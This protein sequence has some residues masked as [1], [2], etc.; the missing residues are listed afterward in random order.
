MRPECLRVFRPDIREEVFERRADGFR[1]FCGRGLRFRQEFDP[2][3]SVNLTD[4][5]SIA[6]SHDGLFSE[7]STE[8]T[9]LLNLN[10]KF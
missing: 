3:M 9:C 2:G 7:N 10:W 8:N 5:L 4:S 1:R 6:A